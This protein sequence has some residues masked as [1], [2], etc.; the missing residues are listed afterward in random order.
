[1]K[2]SSRLFKHKQPPRISSRVAIK[3]GSVVTEIG[4]GAILH[5]LFST[6]S[7][8]LEPDGWGTAFP[9]TMNQLY[10]G[11]LAPSDCAA[12]LRELRAIEE[13]LAEVPASNIV[14]DIENRMSPP[15][16]HYAAGADARNAA[17]YFVTVNG[18]NLL[19][20]GL[21]E[22]VESALEFGDEVR[23]ITF[24]TPADFFRDKA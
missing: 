16:P 11:S 15:N 8:N 23:I 5:G 22:S 17:D 4:A 10:Q 20:H 24:D 1:M 14:W 2:L 18:L 12:A 19:R 7:A 21:I 9:V 13:A 3:S 6:I